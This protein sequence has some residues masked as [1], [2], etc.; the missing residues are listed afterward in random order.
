MLRAATEALR[1]V[2]YQSG[3]RSLLSKPTGVARGTAGARGRGQASD[4]SRTGQATTGPHGPAGRARAKPRAKSVMIQAHASPLTRSRGRSRWVSRC[5]SAQKRWSVLTATR[6]TWTCD[7][8]CNLT[9]RRNEISSRARGSPQLPHRARRECRLGEK[10]DRR[11][12][13]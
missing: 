11:H 2:T 9:H 8:I 1:F 7:Q 5:C 4:R 10:L 13:I 6:Y 3:E 12:V